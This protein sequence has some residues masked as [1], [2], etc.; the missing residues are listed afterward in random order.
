MFKALKPHS[1]HESMKC[2][3]TSFGNMLEFKAL[4]GKKRKIFSEIIRQ[5]SMV[6]VGLNL[7]VLNF[8][9]F[10]VD[11]HRNSRDWVGTAEMKSLTRLD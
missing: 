8:V 4:K 10:F 3:M 6:H 2:L 9:G 7:F 5:F 1:F 11:I